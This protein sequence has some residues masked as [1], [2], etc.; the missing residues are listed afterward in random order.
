MKKLIN[1]LILIIA[2]CFAVNTAKA[3]PTA[4]LVYPANGAQN[5]TLPIT[6]T[7]SVDEQGYFIY[8]LTISNGNDLVY[9]DYTDATSLVVNNLESNTNYSW[10]ITTYNMLDTSEI[11]FSDL[12]YFT[13]AGSNPNENVALTSPENGALNIPPNNISFNWQQFGNSNNYVFMLSAYPS[14][15]VYDIE[16]YTVGTSFT[17]QNYSI[18]Q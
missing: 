3:T 8:I 4:Q 15:L 12:H 13:V 2:V 17:I 16:E 18:K 6:F 9:Q 7:W 5:V 11:A 1:Y 14:F 10:Y